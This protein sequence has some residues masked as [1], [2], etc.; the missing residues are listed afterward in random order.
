[1]RPAGTH[2]Q[3]AFTLFR[4][5]GRKDGMTWARRG[6]LAAALLAVI[7]I[8]LPSLATGQQS[9]ACRGC[10]AQP[11]NAERWSARLSGQWT[12]AGGAAGTVP[13]SGQAYVA[14]GGGIAVVGDGL[15]V[16]AYRL[17]DGAPLWQVTLAAPQGTTI[18]S[19][20]AWPGVVTAGIVSPSDTARTEVVIDSATGTELRRYPAAVFGGAVAA[21]TQTTVVVG[22]SSVTS[23]DNRTGA[24]RWRRTTGAGQ[25]W[26]ADGGTLY[27]AESAGGF[28]GT[29]PVTGLRVI[30]LSSGAERTLDSPPGSPFSGTLAGA[31]DGAVL[32]TSA[33]GVTAYSGSTGGVLWS[34]GG[35]VPEGTDPV[36]GLVYL[37]S[38]SG[39][40]TSVDPVTGKVV[41]TVRGSATTGS[42][43]MYVVRG[44]VALG[45]D[46][47]ADGDAW[48][49]NVATGRVIWTASGLPW[50]HYF[51]D[52]S[53]VG[54]S[55]A[56]SGSTVVI[57]ACPHL[58]PATPPSP[59]PARSTSPS[60]SATPSATATPSPSATGS[61][62]A[63]ATL[64][65]T[66]TGSPH[67]TATPSP[68]LTATPAPVPLCADPELVALNV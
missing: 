1:M 55:A 4:V 36:G 15:T 44:G 67:A 31:V 47:G 60:T 42:A 10:H 59:V 46:S 26:H 45:L 8:P 18:L 56:A 33:S 6:V 54:G 34:V 14:V 3:I 12:A 7:V 39:A 30:D 50:P 63:T 28:I 19:V 40:L 5:T 35:A 37:T 21:S 65:G 2:R 53:G 29:A 23:Y 32:F 38:G 27:V 43:G 62:S 68:T 41:A 57:A 52:L 61:P 17:S 16:S 20:R 51:S 13:V 64:S 24:I 49:Y 48:G 22:P 11:V 9:P 66:A 58:A 25:S